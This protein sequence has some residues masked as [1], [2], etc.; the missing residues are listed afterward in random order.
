MLRVG[1]VDD[2]LYDLEKL[3]AILSPLPDIQIM[4]ETQDA[5]EAYRE[6][7][8][9]QIDLLIADIEMPRLSGYE[10]ADLI[11]SHALNVKVIFVTGHSGY[12]IHAFELD[13]HDYIM[14]PYP[15]ER[16]LKSIERL[17]KKKRAEDEELGRLIIKQKAEIHFIPKKEIIFVE[18]TGRS[19][20]IVT[21][22]GTFETY[23][24]LNELE[25]ELQSRDFFRA[26]RSFIINIHFV[27]NFAVYTKHSYMVTFSQTK[28]K[29]FLAKNK[30]EEFQERYF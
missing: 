27:K 21:T 5:E 30:M 26:H 9:Q 18:R 1:L 17:K 12:A 25:A 13:V 22:T 14:K 20:S 6:V 15:K 19:T 2:Q 10:L 29:A 24:S 3:K 28:A 11:H 23:Q 16:L 4:F 8:K 7:R